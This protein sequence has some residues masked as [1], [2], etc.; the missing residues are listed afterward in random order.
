MI[1]KANKRLWMLRRLKNLGAEKEDLLEVYVKQIRCLLELAVPAWQSSLTIAEKTDIERVQ[2]SACH[3]ILGGLY[4]S[5]TNALEV[6]NLES[7]EV[8]RNNL[9]LKFALK[10]EKH[11]KFQYW[12]KKNVKNVNTRHSTMK[13]CTVKANHTRFEKSPISYLTRLLNTYYQMK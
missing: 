4:G 6:L 11:E 7:L 10:A 3:T 1:S 8:R 5:Y 13:Y 2:K 9:C 12:F